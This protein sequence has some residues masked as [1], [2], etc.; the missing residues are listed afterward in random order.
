MEWEQ[1][2]TLW[3]AAE[4]EHQE[5]VDERRGASRAP[6]LDSLASSLS[7]SLL[8]ADALG[9]RLPGGLAQLA[10]PLD[11]QPL[12]PQPHSPSRRAT[13]EERLE[14]NRLRMQRASIEDYA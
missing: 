5:L 7:A 3:R 11:G 1:I 13:V 14:R 12:S 8:A 6:S 4:Q 9:E 10:F 2:S